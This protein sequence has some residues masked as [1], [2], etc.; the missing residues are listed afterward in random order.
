MPIFVRAGAIIPLDPVRQYTSQV[1]REPTTLRVYRGTDG[2]YT[3]FEDDGISQDYL[4]RKGT[5]TRMRWNERSARL[6]LAPGP[7]DD[8]TN[9]MAPRT[10]TVELIPDG[11]TRTVL[12]SG[13]R[14]DVRF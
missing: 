12:Y 5:W 14:V 4:A 6:T 10:F 8:A 13:R 2:E 3:L 1:V 9:V 11:T 7:P